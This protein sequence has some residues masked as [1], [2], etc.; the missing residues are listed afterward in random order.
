MLAIILLSILSIVSAQISTHDPFY[1]F[2]TDPIRPQTSMFTTIS[3]YDQIRGN[4]LQTPLSNCTPSRFWMI[5][6]GG[7]RLPGEPEIQNLS[8]LS[9]NLRSRVDRSSELG[10]AQLCRGDS[11]NL[12]AWRFDETITANRSLEL[13]TTG[14]NELRDLATRLQNNFPGILP[15]NYLPAQYR[16]RHTY[17]ER[18]ADSLSA[19][20]DGLFGHTNVQFD[21]IPELDRLLRVS[22]GF[23]D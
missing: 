22:W 17:R 2:A 14:W 20:A 8:N 5:G 4:S 11:E 10:R 12:L 13:T 9:E 7:T 3:A 16:F 18:T 1:C 19:F 21:D 15:R 6:R 23:F